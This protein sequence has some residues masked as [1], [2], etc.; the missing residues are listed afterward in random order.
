MSAFPLRVKQEAW[1]ELRSAD[2]ELK[3]LEET[4][5]LITTRGYQYVLD[6]LAATN[7]SPS[8]YDEMEGMILGTGVTA[9]ALGDTDVET[10]IPSSFKALDNAPVVTGSSPW[11][12]TWQ[13][14]W[15]A[16]EATDSGITEAC[17][18]SAAGNAD[19]INRIVFSA[20]DKSA[21]DILVVKV[22]WTIA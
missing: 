17:I 16:G 8:S 22:T 2:G 18:K 1:I 13:T 5:N 11:K 3:C 20:Q 21:T 7:A 10:E 15:N 4:H 19:A 12:I 6:R 14:T 9:A